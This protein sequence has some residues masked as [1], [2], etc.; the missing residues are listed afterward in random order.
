MSVIAI[1]GSRDFKDYD[2]L[3]TEIS[4][5]DIDKIV[6]GGAKGADLLAEHY[7]RERNIPV[8]VFKPDWKLGRHAGILRNKVIVDR[9]DAVVAFWNGESYGTLSTIK[10]A[11]KTGKPVT[12]VIIKNNSYEDSVKMRTE[13]S[14]I[15]DYTKASEFYLN[16]TFQEDFKKYSSALSAPLVGNLQMPNYWFYESVTG[17]YLA[18]R[19]NLTFAEQ[20]QFDLENP[21]EQ[22]FTIFDLARNELAWLQEPF[23]AIDYP[24]LGKSIFAHY[25]ADTLEKNKLAINE[26]YFKRSVAKLILRK[27]IQD[28]LLKND[29]CI[30]HSMNHTLPY[31][32][33]YVS[34]LVAKTGKSLDFDQ[35]WT[36][37]SAPKE[38]EDIVSI[39]G[40]EIQNFLNLPKEGYFTRTAWHK[41]AACWNQVK[42]LPLKIKIPEGLL[43][44]QVAELQ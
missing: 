3:K 23:I 36:S 7:A 33:A 27:Y 34:Y 16:S 6:T 25:L 12:I 29:W 5:F 35:I 21:K 9:S 15:A 14:G 1:V 37:Q 17:E 28:V 30:R 32:L 19:V 40:R 42:V 4:Q 41:E 10:H 13:Y 8:E 11:K 39:A 18:S 43:V 38:L 31:T 24:T 26:L 2:V 44:E 22:M 20:R